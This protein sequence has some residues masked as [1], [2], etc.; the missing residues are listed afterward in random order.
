MRRHAAIPEA[1]RWSLSTATSPSRLCGVAM[2]GAT[3][4]DPDRSTAGWIAATLILTAALLLMVLRHGQAA[5]IDGGTTPDTGGRV[6][7]IAIGFAAVIP[8]F[9]TRL[10]LRVP[11][12]VVP[13]TGG[14]SMA[15]LLALWLLVTTGRDGAAWSLYGGLQVLRARTT[16]ADID[17][18]ARALECGGCEQWPQMHGP[19]IYLF[20]WLTFG[21][22]SP[23]WV[24]P[25]GLAIALTLSAILAWLS[26]QASNFGR[27]VLLIAALSPAWLLLLDRANL[28][29][30]LVL[31]LA[32][33]ALLVN[34]R[35]SLV[36]WS[37]FA[38]FIFIAG[39]IKYYPFAAALALLPALR[40]R[41]GWIVLAGFATATAAYLLL[42]RDQL[43][44]ASEYNALDVTI[45]YDFPAY[46]RL[47]VLDRLGGGVAGAPLWYVGTAL[48]LFLVISAA[49][50]GWRWS[51]LEQPVGAPTLALTLGGSAAF[52]AAVF[53][54]GFG[55]MYKGP[56]L[57]L[58]VPLIAGT[59]A[60]IG[61]SRNRAALFGTLFVLVNLVYT[62]TVAYSS[63]L[64]T[65]AGLIV[66]G[67]A[68]G[69][70]LAQTTRL[71]AQARASARLSQVSMAAS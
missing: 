38:A 16:F 62:M 21:A 7:F 53:V 15:T 42:I 60:R 1:P 14:L 29:A 64:T 17:W 66:A 18:V 61:Q 48:L 33:G 57:L 50:W 68:L 22:F 51:S 32:F 10:D 12:W 31:A 59:A 67:F 19:A 69:A 56:F 2:T 25:L 35:E 49:G 24:V 63:L 13:I 23:S 28:D 8:A 30:L 34:R 45:L 20:E 44:R 47:I 58:T 26:L 43:A 40:L 9:I 54:S 55:Y 3:E 65:L 39:A 46:G 37:A 6:A 11:R 5:S 52:L 4:A 36:T 27:V 41:R 70:G 71:V